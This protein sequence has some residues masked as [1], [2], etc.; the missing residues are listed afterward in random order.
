MTESTKAIIK[1]IRQ[2]SIETGHTYGCRRLKSQL[3]A[4]SYK[5]GTHRKRH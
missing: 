5:I 2:I 1:S 4:D 3:N